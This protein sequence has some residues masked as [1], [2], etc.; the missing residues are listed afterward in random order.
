M[1][2][3]LEASTWIPVISW[4]AAKRSDWNHAWDNPR[5]GGSRG[6]KREMIVAYVL[7]VCANFTGRNQQKLEGDD[8]Y[9]MDENEAE[10]ET[11]KQAA[12]AGNDRNVNGNNYG[13][14]GGV[15]TFWRQ[16]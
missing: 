12:L 13:G 11:D 6:I 9:S 1:P 14:S 16:L 8:D 10:S 7:C 4:E 3:V 5:L 15:T 2:C